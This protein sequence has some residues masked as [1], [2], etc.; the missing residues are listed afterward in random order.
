[1]KKITNYCKDSLK[2][3][4]NVQMCNFQSSSVILFIEQHFVF[5]YSWLFL[6]PKSIGDFA[7]ESLEDSDSE[8]S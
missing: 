2:E 5:A 1:M 6:F 8:K 7:E 4:H 3:R